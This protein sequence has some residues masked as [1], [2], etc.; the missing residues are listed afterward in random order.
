MFH[1]IK[2]LQNEEITL[3]FSNVNKLCPTCHF[4]VVN[5]SINAIR[6]VKL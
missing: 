1:E 6:E 2:P 4:N 3:R 5:M